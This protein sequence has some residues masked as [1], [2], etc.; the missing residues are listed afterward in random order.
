MGSG[1]IQEDEGEAEQRECCLFHLSCLLKDMKS[2]YEIV[3]MF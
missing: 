2:F 3:I 1:Q